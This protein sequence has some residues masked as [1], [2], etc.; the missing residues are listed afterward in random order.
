MGTPIS[1]AGIGLTFSGLQDSV[2]VRRY[3]TSQPNAGAGGIERFY[4]VRSNNPSI[5][6]AA[7]SSTYLDTTE[8]NGYGDEANFKLFVSS[9]QGS[10]WT[11]L[12]STVD[13]LND[14]VSATQA[15]G[16]QS[17]TS[18]F[19]IASSDCSNPPVDSIG[20]D[21]SFCDGDFVL[22]NAGSG[23]GYR[24]LWNTGDTTQTLAVAQTDTLSVTLTDAAGCATSD[25]IIVTRNPLPFVGLTDSVSACPGDFATLDAQN[26]GFSFLW[27]TSD[28][29]QSI[30]ITHADTNQVFASI[31]VVVTDSNGCQ[32]NDTAIFRHDPPPFVDLGGNQSLCGGSNTLL[33]AAFSGPSGNVGVSYLW[34]TGATSS[35]ITVGTTGNYSVQ[36]TNTWSCTATDTVSV[37]VA[38]A[39]AATIS[40]TNITCNGASDGSVDLTVSGG[41]LP[42]SFSWNTTDTTE[43]LSGLAPGTY[44]VTI[45]DSL[46][47]TANTSIAITQP[48][49]LVYTMSA[50]DVTCFGDQDGTAAV[51]TL[52]GGTTPFSFLWSNSSTQQNQTSLGPGTFSVTVSDSNGCSFTDSVSVT[53]PPQLTLIPS[54][55]NNPGCASAATGSIDIDVAGGT[56]GYTYLWSTGATTQDL[57]ALT[58][59]TYSITATDQN[60]CSVADTFTLTE[61][62]A[63]VLSESHGDL[64]CNGDQSGI[65]DLTVSGGIGPYGFQW[66]NGP[67]TEDLSGLSGGTYSVTVTDANNCQDTLS[68]SLVEPT[69][70]ALSLSAYDAACGS[71]NGSAAVSVSGGTPGY[72]FF[73]PHN[74]SILDSLSGLAA[75]I[76]QVRVTDGNGCLDSANAVINN[77][78]AAVITLDSVRQVSCNGAMDG[79]ISTSAT[80]GVPPFTYLWNNGGTTPNLTNIGP[81]T[82]D[83]TLTAADGCQAFASVVITEPPALTSTGIETDLLCFGDLSGAIDLIPGGGVGPYNY[84]WNTGAT[85]E[86]LTG[87][88]A[89]GFQVTITDANNCTLT[90]SFTLSEP[91]EL[92]LAHLSTD[93]SCSGGNDG[94]ID[95]L[96]NGGT[97]G[98]S[99]AWSNGQN[100]EDQTGLV[101]RN[102][103]SRS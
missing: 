18:L 98:Y 56:P 60:L 89:G 73:W 8:T 77:A 100:S 26:P 86:D 97:P 68:V 24:Y 14:V 88:P 17:D 80:G 38:P 85:S 34:N 101:C 19:T 103:F 61:P 54:A 25:T 58:A 64:L 1:P 11:G 31:W 93:A 57:N 95:L 65:I 55:L 62:T 28:T 92:T 50:S 53:E 102:L 36:V 75:G 37:D 23:P 45:T 66:S 72:N 79:Y 74:G 67:T 10:S 40:G 29:T 76:Y 49:A 32:N 63:L 91:A 39:L 96:V 81:G 59:G 94:A 78:G 35:A 41:T 70:I 83:L 15:Q 21:T 82:Y 47:C 2:F 33:D 42:Y 9:D 99:F 84:L 69:A 44:S 16:V 20:N 87:L 5:Q 48:A 3:F 52:T 4:Q 7:I 30:A 22:L 13:S 43:D 6:S 71:S 46:N 51:A 90:D 12:T 27:S